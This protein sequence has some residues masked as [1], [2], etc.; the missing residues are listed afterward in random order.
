MPLNNKTFRL[1]RFAPDPFG[2][3]G[4]KR[5][6]QIA[7]ILEENGFNISELQDCEK[8]NQ[9]EFSNIRDFLGVLNLLRENK[10]KI[11]SI[12]KL[13]RFIADYLRLKGFFQR[14]DFP[15]VIVWED[16]HPDKY[17]VALIAKHFKIPLIALPHNLESLVPGQASALSGISAPFFFDEELIALKLC[18]KVFTISREEQWLLGLYGIEAKYLPY[19]PPK[20]A[21]N[22]LLAI[23]SERS[24]TARNSTEILIIGTYYNNPTKIGM[25]EIIKDI[26]KSVPDYGAY[27]FNI[28]GFGTEHLSKDIAIPACIN[29]A[30]SVDNNQLRQLL[31]KASAVLVTQPATTGALTKIPEILMAG[32]PI[33]LN[34]N[35]AR[36]NDNTAGTFVIDQLCEIHDILK[37][38]PDLAPIPERPKKFERQF[39]AAVAAASAS[40]AII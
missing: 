20:N 38:I 37:I 7:E 35:A 32:V 5:T 16:T 18:T 21:I 13:T 33:I 1:S 22:Y 19:Y 40:D 28:A 14:R 12:L 2:H 3:G 25:I 9:K 15:N 27:K 30:G 11:S 29:I 24:R 17:F 8:P 23:R 26:A 39:L 36:S 6:A 4:Q 34:S 31:V 10:F